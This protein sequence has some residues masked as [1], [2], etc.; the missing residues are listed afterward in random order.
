MPGRGRGTSA[1][2]EVE[3]NKLRGWRQGDAGSTVV[4]KVGGSV[5]LDRDRTE[6]R[7]TSEVKMAQNELSK[8]TAKRS[9]WG[10]DVRRMTV[11]THPTVALRI[12]KCCLLVG[13][14]A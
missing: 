4:A 5:G 3:F 8:D 12:T 11:Y 13:G 2:D 7:G 6:G 1:A 9:S 10:K 14:T